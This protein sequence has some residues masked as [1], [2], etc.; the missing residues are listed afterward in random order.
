MLFNPFKGV[1]FISENESL[2]LKIHLNDQN[3]VFL[4]HNPY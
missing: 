1:I 3:I 2:T 4:L